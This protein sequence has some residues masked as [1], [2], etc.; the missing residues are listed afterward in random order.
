MSN[1]DAFAS[2]SIKQRPLLFYGAHEIGVAQRADLK[3][4]DWAV[5]FI[6][7]RRQES[8]VTVGVLGRS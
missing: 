4:V 7:K 5:K 1:R 3:Q 2:S 8:K 6:L